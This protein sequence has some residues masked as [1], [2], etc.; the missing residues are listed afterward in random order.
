MFNPKESLLDQQ[1]AVSGLEMQFDPFT[2]ISAGLS[3]ASGFAGASSASRANKRA[4]R[5]RKAQQKAAEKQAAAT[6]KYNKKLYDA[7]K[8]NYFNNKEFQYDTAV[9]EWK[10]NQTIA[11]Y[12]YNQAVKEYSKSVENTEQQLLFNSMAAVDAYESE[13]AAFNEILSEDAFN[14]QG[15]L[16]DRLEQGGAAAL[17]QPGR[18]RMKGIQSRLAA[19]GRNSA[20]RDASI[21]SSAE[22]NQ[23]NMRGIAL[24]KYGADLQARASMMIKP[25]ALPDIPKPE[26]G[27][28]MIFVPPMKATPAY[29]PAAPQQSTMAPLVAGFGSAAKSL[30]GVDWP[31]VFGNSGS[32]GDSSGN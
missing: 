19:S 27:P 32:S 18:G 1:L 22:Q 20:V 5:D 8:K 15:D 13:Q 12:K 28:D 17:G 9:K 29:I 31:N 21:A 23:R 14:R 7:K 11:D 3:I 30:V 16:V 2:A 4:K 10:Y 24:Q 6:N 26:K 25:E